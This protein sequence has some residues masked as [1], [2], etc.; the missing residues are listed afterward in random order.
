LPEAAVSDTLRWCARAASCEVVFTYVDRRVLESPAAFEGTE[1]LFATLSAASERWTFGL[2]PL[3]LREFLAERG[4]ALDI[5]LGAREYRALC[6]GS[7]AD[8]MRGSESY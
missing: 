1:K 8:A 7:T 4:L 5:D 2:D 6:Y 3:H